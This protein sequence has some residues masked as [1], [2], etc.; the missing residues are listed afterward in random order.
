MKNSLDNLF[1]NPIQRIDAIINE[2]FKDCIA[3]AGGQEGVDLLI[4][5][6][7]VCL[8]EDI[9]KTGRCLNGFC[10]GYSDY[11]N[12]TPFMFDCLYDKDLTD[13]ELILA[14]LSTNLSRQA[15]AAI[16]WKGIH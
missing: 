4:R 5:Q 9:F 15:R 11:L 16:E 13:L 14:E 10:P 8:I 3:E 6:S 2:L 12:P 7:K 1:D